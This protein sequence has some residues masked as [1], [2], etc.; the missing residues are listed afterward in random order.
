MRNIWKSKRSWIGCIY[1][2]ALIAASFIY[3]WYIKDTLPKPEKILYDSKGHAIA[4]APLSP[5]EYPPLGTDR[6]GEPLIYKILEG[7][8]YTIGLALLIGILRIVTGSVFGIV[9]GLYT[10]KFIKLLKGFN[11]AFYYI[12]T[13]FLAFVL[14]VPVF[15]NVNEN[16]EPVNPQLS[17]MLFQ[18]AVIILLAVPS[19]VVFIGDEVDEFLQKEYVTSSV[20]M[21]ATKWHLLKKHIWPFLKDKLLV[22]FMQQV[23]Q[24]L[25]LFTHLGLLGLFFGG[26]QTIDIDDGVQKEVSLSN[27]WSGLIGIDFHEVNLAPWVV[28]VPLAAFAATIFFLNLMTEGIK[29]ALQA[30]PTVNLSESANEPASLKESAVQEENM[31]AFA[32]KNNSSTLD[33]S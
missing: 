10:K 13:I 23:V 8:K 11:Q 26:S 20:I 21:G 6:L 9:M 1:I 5:L 27:E 19:I 3:S 14:I 15:Y 29:E 7:A 32:H 31:F 22:L 4:A 25:I 2:I 30:R 24:T 16:D 33:A 28:L 18:A 17:L 12:P